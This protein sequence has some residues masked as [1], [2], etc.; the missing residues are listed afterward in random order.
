MKAAAGRS[1]LI[2]PT[3]FVLGLS[4]LCLAVPLIQAQTVS[5]TSTTTD[6]DGLAST[7]LTL[8][9][10]PTEYFVT[11]TCPT[12]RPEAST[13]TFRV[14]GKL[15]NDDFKQFDVR[16]S[17]N[18]YDNICYL[19]TDTAKIV[20]NCQDPRLAGLNVLPFTIGAKG[21]SMS[22]MAM[23]I[24][25]YAETFPALGVL[26]T[27]PAGLNLALGAMGK[28]GFG[29]KGDIKWKAIELVSG[30]NI[31]HDEETDFIDIS[32]SASAS[33]RTTA[34][35]GSA[36][37]D[38]LSSQPGPVIF[39]FQ[40]TKLTVSGELKK[41]NHF[42]LAVGKCGGKYV[43]ADPGGVFQSLVDP[44]EV[45]VRD[46]ATQDTAGPLTGVRRF[47]RRIP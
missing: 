3:L 45:I 35:A 8:G 32:A 25:Y 9:N 15:E 46:S 1:G 36:D 37:P 6:A 2:F 5:P 28:D 29:S 43:L 16:W 42:V 18:T 20:R 23:L 19:S 13:V 31:K 30:K 34:L 24:N 38:L 41:W 7:I 44:N 22:A 11:A 17:S 33:N 10:I 26:S 4:P 21:C 40:R 27:T 14:C 47:R 39:R 12:C